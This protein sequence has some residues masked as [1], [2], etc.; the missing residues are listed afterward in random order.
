[1]FYPEINIEDW[2]QEYPLLKSAL[3]DK[4]LC[5]ASLEGHKAVVTKGK[6]GVLAGP[7]KS[8]DLPGTYWSTPI[9]EKN[10]EK[11]RKLIGSVLS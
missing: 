6:V 5:G 9:T 10:K 2:V 3:T 1:M 8:C 11:H 7:C 4:C